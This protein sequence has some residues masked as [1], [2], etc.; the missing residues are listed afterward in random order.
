MADDA[1]Q[2]EIRPRAS[3]RGLGARCLARGPRRQSRGSALSR[4]PR[5]ARSSRNRRERPAPPPCARRNAHGRP[6]G[7][8]DALLN[9]PPQPITR[10]S[11]LKIAVFGFPMLR[12][13]RVH[14]SRRPLFLHHLAVRRARSVPRQA[15]HGLRSKRETRRRSSLWRGRAFIGRLREDRA[16]RKAGRALCPVI[17]RLSGLHVKLAALA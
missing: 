14:R 12:A 10:S 8:H 13:L 9:P 11:A 17:R 1:R 3:R 4:V 16:R 6:F 2:A 15:R 5:G 7:R